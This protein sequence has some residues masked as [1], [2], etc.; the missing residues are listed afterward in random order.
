MK[1][2]I[3]FALIM[4]SITTAMVSFTLIAV[5]KG[6]DS[7]FIGTWLSSWLVSYLV[8]VPSILIIGPRVQALLEGFPATDA[9]EQNYMHK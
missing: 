2:K 1:Q 4:G 6:F 9:N 3:L 8:A 7:N 5:N